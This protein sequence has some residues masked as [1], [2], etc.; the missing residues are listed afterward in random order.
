M[1]SQGNDVILAISQSGETAD[2]LAGIREAKS[3]FF[4]VLSFVNVKNSTIDR[5]SDAVIYSHSGQ[6]VGVA[7][8][9]TLLHN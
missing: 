2:T 3:H 8:T 9:K 7:S 4:R 6:E 5:E 1:I